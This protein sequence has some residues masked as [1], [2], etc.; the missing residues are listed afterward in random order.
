MSK[1]EIAE[2][3]KQMESYKSK[4][5]MG[6]MLKDKR[7]W[8][9][10]LGLG[11][12]WMTTVRIVSRLIPRLMFMGYAEN[13]ALTMLTVAAICG[14][15]GS[16]CWGWLDQKLGTRKTS[17]IY[18]VWYIIALILLIVENNAAMVAA[19]VIAGIG[20]GGIGNLV[21]SMIGTVYGRKD[22][23]MANK[24]IMPLCA[25]IRSC[26]FVLMSAIMGA[27]GSYTIA[28]SVFIGACVIGIIF[29]WLIGKD[30][31][32]PIETAL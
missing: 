32:K 13:T 29:V 2:S 24:V 20:I 28:Y 5:T 25:I 18:G 26:A 12:M 7:A 6:V 17:V 31:D 22:Y 1:E 9:I 23:L 19:V 11:L 8:A 16:Y 27:T 15:F 10:G 30:G 14:I 4:L 3:K 21:P